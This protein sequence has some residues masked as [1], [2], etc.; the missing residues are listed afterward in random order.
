MFAAV[1][2][3]AVLGAA[4]VAVALASTSRKRKTRRANLTVTLAP[5][6][7]SAGL[8][9]VQNRAARSAEWPPAPVPAPTIPR[10]GVGLERIGA[11]SFGHAFDPETEVRAALSAGHPVFNRGVSADRNRWHEYHVF[12][13]EGASDLLWDWAEETRSP[14]FRDRAYSG[15]AALDA[16]R[17]AMAGAAASN[18]PDPILARAR[19]KREAYDAR[20]RKLNAQGWRDLESGDWVAWYADLW[21]SGAAA[22]SGAWDAVTDPDAW[23]S[24]G[25]AGAGYTI[26]LP[27][28]PTAA[29]L[30]LRDLY[31]RSIGAR[32]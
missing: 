20:M 26:T 17:L 12:A 8:A 24:R 27:W 31:L 1:A 16:V 15:A 14:G 23:K 4:G 22:L 5:R 2:I 19:A 13:V 21:K 10:S 3:V 29:D 30:Y 11:P 32:V 18:P 9:P 28:T 25:G 7:A 6:P